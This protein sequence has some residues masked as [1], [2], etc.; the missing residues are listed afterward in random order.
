M[1]PRT[2]RVRQVIL[3]AAFEA[4]LADGAEHVTATRV[5]ER[6]DV[7]RTTIYRHWPD[8]ASLLLATIDAVTSPHH[9]PPDTGPL[10]SDLRSALENLRTRLVMRETRPVFGALASYAHHDEGFAAAQRRF[11]EQL[12]RPVAAVLEAARERGEV[13]GELDCRLEATLLAGPVLQHHLILHADI[14]DGLIET[15]VARWLAVHD[16]GKR[17]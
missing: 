17:L 15:V 4:L 5:A 8:Q 1:N 2:R 9:P 12:V 14:A 7:A 6:A 10:D 16:L 11:V 13:G 3:A